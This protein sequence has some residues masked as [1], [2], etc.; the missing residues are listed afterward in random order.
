MSS[1]NDETSGMAMAF[2]M[3]AA[4]MILIG[5]VIYA[6]A[7]LTALAL[8]VVSFIAWNKPFTLWGT[9]VSPEESRRFVATGLIGAAV[10]PVLAALAAILFR[11]SIQES[12]VIH[13]VL[14]GYTL[15]SLGVAYIDYK[16]AE[17]QEAEEAA[18]AAVIA[19]TPEMP[20]APRTIQPEPE[21]FWFAEWSDDDE[22]RK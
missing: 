11:F 21:E 3:I 16:N 22:V 17:A 2:A 18:R 9:T 20:P 15:G 4:G 10:T 12:F 6:L 7:L 1:R 14:G 8:T 5:V 19:P 13:L